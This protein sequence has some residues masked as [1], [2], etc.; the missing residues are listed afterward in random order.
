MA[1]LLVETDERRQR[2]ITACLAMGVVVGIYFL[3]SIL[4]HSPISHAGPGHLVYG[5]EPEVP[6][7]IKIAY[8]IVT[9]LTAIL[10]SFSSLRLF[11][12]IVL[13]GSLTSY[14]FYWEAF[15]SVWCFFAAAASAV[16]I[17]HFQRVRQAL[18][19]EVSR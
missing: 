13:V 2:L 18:N 8:F 10:S 11:G 16:I 7:V 4:N 12:G 14:F 5:G 6:L 15:S 3:W 19:A 9:G 17:L 1:A